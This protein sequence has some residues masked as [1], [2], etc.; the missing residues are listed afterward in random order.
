MGR[1][2]TKG[3]DVN[4]LKGDKVK[5]TTTIG[6][7]KT[8]HEFVTVYAGS[9][10]LMSEDNEFY[11]SDTYDF[12]LIERPEPAWMK[13]RI[14]KSRGIYYVS[15][16]QGWYIAYGPSKI[17]SNFDDRVPIANEEMS[18]LANIEVIA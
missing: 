1:Q 9:D 15:D 6:K 17:W 18:T 10:G 4:F 12:E 16:S 8:A 3:F 13:A 2:R 14:I 5:A 7:T 11:P